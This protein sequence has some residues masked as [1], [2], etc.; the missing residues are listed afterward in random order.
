MARRAARVSRRRSARASARL[1][2]H[3][4]GLARGGGGCTTEGAGGGVYVSGA[5]EAPAGRVCACGPVPK[6]CNRCEHQTG[7]QGGATKGEDAWAAR[8]QH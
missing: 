8:V 5:E 3:R 2:L 6:A 1:R 4:D 7:P